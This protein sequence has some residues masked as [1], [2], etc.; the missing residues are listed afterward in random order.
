MG[1]VAMKVRIT[2]EVE[3]EPSDVAKQCYPSLAEQ[4]L[5]D[6]DLLVMVE[7]GTIANAKAEVIHE[8]TG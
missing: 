2:L 1:E 4:W 6:Y 8:A 7:E 5:S 3:Y